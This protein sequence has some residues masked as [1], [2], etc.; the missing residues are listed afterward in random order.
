MRT[1]ATN[2]LALL[3]LTLA[4]TSEAA[5][6]TK[7]KAL[8]AEH[9]VAC[10]GL[11]GKGNGPTG[12]TLDPKPTDFTTATFDEERWFQATKMGTK[13]VPGK[14]DKMEGFAAKLSDDDIRDVVAYTQTLK[15]K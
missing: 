3:M 12:K 10:H 7:G 8:Y 1:D 15:A 13:P 6:P 4:S 5:D 9:C 11:H 14:K 2:W